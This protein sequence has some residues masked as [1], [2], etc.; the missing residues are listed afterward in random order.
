MRLSQRCGRTLAA[1]WLPCRCSAGA[2]RKQSF[3]FPVEAVAGAGLAFAVKRL[4]VA[5]KVPQGDVPTE[6]KQILNLST[7][8]GFCM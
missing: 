8:P 6:S 3:D 1:V 2:Q 7:V 4:L 5:D